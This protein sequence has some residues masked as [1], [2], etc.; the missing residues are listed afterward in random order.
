MPVE[1]PFPTILVAGKQAAPLF[2]AGLFAVPHPLRGE[3][4]FIRQGHG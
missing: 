1:R 3:H 4:Y 2:T